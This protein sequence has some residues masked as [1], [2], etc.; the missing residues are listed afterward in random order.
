VDL[1]GLMRYLRT[2][3]GVRCLLSEGGPR[4][5]AQLLDGDL[6]DE[7]FVTH[8]PKLAGGDGPGLAEGMRA[9]ARDLEL[10][11]LL[12]DEGT[13]ELFGRYRVPR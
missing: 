10:V 6:V 5:H 12:H 4:V 11:S 2:E 13:G 9:A 3:R 1:P 8:A 7:L